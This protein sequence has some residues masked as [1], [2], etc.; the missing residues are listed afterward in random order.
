MGANRRSPNFTRNLPDKGQATPTDK[1]RKLA[2][3]MEESGRPV[4]AAE[5]SGCPTVHQTKVM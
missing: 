5:P 3:V 2:V 1:G 4:D